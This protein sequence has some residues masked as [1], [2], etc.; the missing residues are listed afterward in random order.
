[1]R[2][3]RFLALPSR[4][5]GVVAIAFAFATLCLVPARA[6]AD[7][8]SP[9]AY[10]MNPG[11]LFRLPPVQQEAHL[12]LLQAQGIRV[13][14]LGA[15]WSDLE[16]APPV[17]GRH[18]YQWGETDDRVAALA[19]HGI[20]WE[21]L[22]CFSATWGSQ[23]EGDYTGSP[24][25]PADFAAFAAALATRYGPGGTFW[26][27]H[28]ELPA[29]PVAA[30]EVWNEQNAPLYWHPTGD[31]AATYADLYAATRSAVHGV[32]AGARVVVG[33]LAAVKDGV[34]APEDFLK[35][36]LAHRPD[37]RGNVDAVGLHPYARDPEGVYAKVAAFRHTL[38]NLVGPG[39]PIEVTEIGWTAAGLTEQVRAERLAAVTSV[40]PRSDCGVERVM[41]YAWIGPELDPDDREQWFGLV[42]A[43]GVPKPP[44]LAYA[45]AIADVLSGRAGGPVAICAR[46]QPRT[47]EAQRPTGPQPS[48]ATAQRATR[49]RATTRA[50]KRRVRPRIGL[51]VAARRSYS[52]GTRLLVR[53]SCTAGCRLRIKVGFARRLRGGGPS[54]VRS[55][56]G[57]TT[58]RLHTVALSL[59][60][61]GGLRG[62]TLRVEVVAVTR[63]G[64][65]RH[66]RSVRVR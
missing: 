41:P 50:A 24:A 51:R 54:L 23:T 2:A 42:T 3:G 34:T 39:V 20:R 6:A 22:L 55:F 37:L 15:W 32:D 64:V 43:D 44:A 66:V 45:A 60:R 65:T 26:Q 62:R 31:P 25:D 63:A 4:L 46:P 12:A 13:M 58:R 57:T 17:D 27:E 40:L 5:H 8:P 1:M 14:R 48:T 53:A 52:R 19:R 29:L 36:M 59:G 61:R 21:P 33:G 10:G 18:T 38:D 49:P 56:A 47:A 7:A 30:Y 28:P 9:E 16:P 35:R 11:D